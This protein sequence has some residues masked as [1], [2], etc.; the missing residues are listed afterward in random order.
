MAEPSTLII[1]VENQVRELDAKILLSCVAAERGFPVVLGSRGYIHQQITEFP[2]G[3]YL[4]KSMRGLSERMFSILRDLGHEIVGWDEEGVVRGPDPYYH[5]RRLSAKALE[6]V[7][8]LFAWGEDDARALRA[9]PGF[10]GIPIHVTGN[11][12]VDLL[13]SDVRAYFDPEVAELRDRFGPFILINTNF[14]LVNHFIPK[15]G[16]GQPAPGEPASGVQAEVLAQLRVLRTGLFRAFQEMVPAISEALPDTAIVIRPH[17]VER[18][19]PWQAVARNHKRV[20]VVS[21]GNVVPWLIAARVLVHNCCTTSVEASILNTPSVAYE[22]VRGEFPES[23]LPNSLSHRAL[24][25]EQLT[26]TLAAIMDGKLGV[27]PEPERRHLRDHIAACEG[28]LASD[29]M[30]DVL[31]AAGY[32]ARRPEPPGGLRYLAGWTVAKLRSLGKRIGSR[33]R[34]HRGSAEYHD[35]RFPDI[36]AELI[37]ERIEKFGAL[38]G[39]FEGLRVRQSSQHIFHIDQA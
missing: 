23:T 7:S 26:R 15:L 21:E 10:P 8:T 12:R 14:A 18:H 30:V 2:R 38:L 34:D 13:R 16:N 33:R 25:L 5:E 22:P 24:D 9:F 20:H 17:P 6:K 1:P 32:L 11:P 27:L 37:R 35:H 28:R 36:S 3:V 39:R 19:E 31:E 4:A 29:R